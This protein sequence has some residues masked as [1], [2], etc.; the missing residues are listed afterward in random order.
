MEIFASRGDVHSIRA[1][2]SLFATFSRLRLAR[3]LARLEKGT[4]LCEEVAHCL[5]E[6]RGGVLECGHRSRRVQAEARESVEA[7][8]F[9]EHVLD[10]AVVRLRKE[11]LKD[12]HSALQIP[13]EAWRNARGGVLTFSICSKS[14][15]ANFFIAETLP[16]KRRM[17]SRPNVGMAAYLDDG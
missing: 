17:V 8:E 3:E 2:S 15:A 16:L 10:D 12:G 7:R 6:G 5:A 4:N 1:L 9:E 14:R 13:S 11:T